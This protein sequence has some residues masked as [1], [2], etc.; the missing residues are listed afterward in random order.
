MRRTG[1]RG[2]L[3][4]AIPFWASF[5]RRSP[6]RGGLTPSQ[7]FGYLS[8][9]QMAPDAY[10][11]LAAGDPYARRPQPGDIYE[12][13]P[14]FTHVGIV[15]QVVREAP[16]PPDQ[17]YTPADYNP[18]IQTWETME[19][20]RGG[21]KMGFDQIGR[22]GLKPFDPAKVNGWIDADALFAGWKAS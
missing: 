17:D 16:L 4:P 7:K 22:S 18:D 1:G 19:G 8:L 11:P 2:A 5:S 12:A 10:I 14:E 6:G 20:G 13:R 21:P 3:L 9:R 15:V